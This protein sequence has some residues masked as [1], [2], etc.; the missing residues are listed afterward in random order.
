M[1]PKIEIFYFKAGALERA[2]DKVDEEAN[3]VCFPASINFK[4][5]R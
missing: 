5:N 1:F 3:V 4:V 2:L